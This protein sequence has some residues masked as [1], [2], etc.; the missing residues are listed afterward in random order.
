MSSYI[1]HDGRT[2]KIQ[3]L[4]REMKEAAAKRDNITYVLRCNILGRKP[5]YKDL[6]DQGVVELT[7]RRQRTL[8][9]QV[10][11]NIIQARQEEQQEPVDYDRR[12]T[13]KINYPRFL[14]LTDSSSVNPYDAFDENQYSEKMRI[15]RE[16]G[17]DKLTA[18]GGK[19][20]L[21]EKLEPSQVLHA[22]SKVYLSAMRWAEKQ[23]KEKAKVQVKPEQE[24]LTQPETAR[25]E[26]IPARRGRRKRPD[27]QPRLFPTE[28]MM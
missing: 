22:F 16:S 18:K 13:T 24:T 27:T 19:G 23:M 12:R 3:K 7:R 17:Y 11:Q 6:Y 28:G 15:L 2:P 1:P 5:E 9:N 14:R 25:Q 4:E 20:E 21:I 26:T 8:E 10:Y